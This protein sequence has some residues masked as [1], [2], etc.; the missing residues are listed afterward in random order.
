LQ[1]GRGGL[2]SRGVCR[3]LAKPRHR[4]EI[5]VLCG[6]DRAWTAYCERATSLT[7]SL[8]LLMYGSFFST[9]IRVKSSPFGNAAFSSPSS[10]SCA[11]LQR[12]QWAC[13]CVRDW[14]SA[15]RQESPSVTYRRRSGRHFFHTS[16]GGST[17]I[18]HWSAYIHPRLAWSQVM[19]F[20]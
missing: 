3:R 6:L 14:F 20:L 16:N 15:L 17:V 4:G 8:S 2:V 13:L 9:S 11:R 7:Q 18:P 5:C 10:A 12:P 1:V 19:R